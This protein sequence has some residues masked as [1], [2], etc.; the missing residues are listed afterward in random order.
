MRTDGRDRNVSQVVSE[1]VCPRHRALAIVVAL[2][3][4]AAVAGGGAAT[5][6]AAD[7]NATAA[8]DG[9]CT[10]GGRVLARDSDVAV[11]EVKSG[12]RT[13]LYACVV[14]TG[15]VHGVLHAGAGTSNVVVAGPY[16]GFAHNSADDEV[17]LDVFDAQTGHTE[18]Q[19]VIGNTCLPG[20]G[21]SD[22]VCGINPW[23]LA[24]DGWVAELDTQGDYPDTFP[25]ISESNLLASNGGYTVTDLDGAVGLRLNGSTL[26]WSIQGGTH[27]SALLGPQLDALGAG[28]VPPPIPTPSPCSLIT[29]ADAQAVLGPVAPT[30]SS[31]SGS[32]CTYTASGGPSSK[33]ALALQ[34]DLTAAQVMSAKTA[35][36]K[37]EAYYY[38]DPP[39]YNE[40]T[41]TATWDTA[42]GGLANSHVVRFVG[43]VE[44]TLDITTLDPSN[45][46]G[47]S[48]G[49]PTL[50]WSAE[51]AAIHFTDLAFDRLMGWQLLESPAS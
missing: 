47:G 27:Y 50:N 37:S 4:I 44:L 41:W 36:Y 24:P 33:L 3:L 8:H 11:W 15:V 48:A 10:P 26:T 40:Y 18:L 16:V 1:L 5:S 31:S 39:R 12:R 29:A 20:G 49:L 23:V 13:A 42:G 51:A 28:T 22:N 43:D 7:A 45:T 9:K 25:G 34:P 46:L 38:T 30:S 2:G 32:G 14:A 17:F 19:H 6:S 35:A 21:G